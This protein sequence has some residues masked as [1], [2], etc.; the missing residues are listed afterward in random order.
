MVL[1][2]I[3]VRFNPY[4]K[5]WDTRLRSIHS[6]VKH[7]LFRMSWHELRD[8]PHDTLCR[9]V[10]IDNSWIGCNLGDTQLHEVVRCQALE[11]I[12]A[13]YYGES[14]EQCIL[15][16]MN[17]HLYTGNR[18]LGRDRYSE[19]RYFPSEPSHCSDRPF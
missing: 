15:R 17:E 2:Y 11:E 18:A 1:I 14:A 19:E 13:E 7:G 12:S 16:T 9:G 10:S 8:L 6:H 3:T 5:N 4:Y